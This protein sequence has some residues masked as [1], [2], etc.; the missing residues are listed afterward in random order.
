MLNSKDT[1][2]LF[3]HPAGP[4][5]EPI[6]DELTRKAAAMWRA[7]RTDPNGYRGVHECTSPGCG[8][9]SDNKNHFVTSPGASGELMTNSLMVHYIAVHRNEISERDLGIVA[10][11]TDSTEPSESEIRGGRPYIR[12]R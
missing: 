4:P 1:H 9:T 5:T 8:V 2:L 11:A 7:R 3:I 6:I 12:T 10:A